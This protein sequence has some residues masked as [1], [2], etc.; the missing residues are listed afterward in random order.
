M[1]GLAA[2]ALLVGLVGLLWYFTEPS[3]AE[4]FHLSEPPEREISAEEPPDESEAAGLPRELFRDVT[5]E[6]GVDAL[7]I[8]QA[9]HHQACADQEE[10]RDRDLGDDQCAARSAALCAGG[11]LRAAF[12]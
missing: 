9:A 7:Q 8:D 6:S 4:E 12:F 2:A 5:A 10:E 3:A 11:G 1:I